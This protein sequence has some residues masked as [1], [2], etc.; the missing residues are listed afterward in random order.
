[1]CFWSNFWNNRFPR[2]LNVLIYTDNYVQYKFLLCYNIYNN[3]HNV[4][5]MHI[6]Y[7]VEIEKYLYHWVRALVNY[8]V[9]HIEQVSTSLQIISG[10]NTATKTLGF[11]WRSMIWNEAV[12]HKSCKES[13]KYMS[14]YSKGKFIIGTTI[15]ETSI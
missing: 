6:T 13:K 4:N 9:F 5:K 15:N 7:L 8:I 10:K 3:I 11:G 2:L 12:S 14:K 1:M